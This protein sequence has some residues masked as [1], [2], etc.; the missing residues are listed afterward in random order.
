MV[1]FN[2]IVNDEPSLIAGGFNVV[3]D[4]SEA[5]NGD[6]S[7]FPGVDDFTGMLIMTVLFDHPWTGHFYTWSNKRNVDR[8][9]RKLNRV[10]INGNWL[11][12]FSDSTVEFLSHI[13]SDH[14]PSSVTVNTQRIRRK[15]SFKF[16]TSGL[17]IQNFCS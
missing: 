17:I 4:S 12:S 8:I 14:S 3:K 1:H 16:F 15:D 13:I 6:T 7:L 5:S 2:N 10:L 11:C 9:A